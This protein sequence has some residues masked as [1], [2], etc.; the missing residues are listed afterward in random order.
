MVIA[1]DL[2]AMWVEKKHRPGTHLFKCY[3]HFKHLMYTYTTH[4]SINFTYFKI[5]VELM[6]HERFVLMCFWNELMCLT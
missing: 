5:S 3:L 2:D 4:I 6:R 1:T